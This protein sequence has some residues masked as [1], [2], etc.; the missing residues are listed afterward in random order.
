MSYLREIETINK[1]GI[2]VDF[3]FIQAINAGTTLSANASIDDTTI[4]LTSTT[5]F[6]DG[7]YV[8]IF[9]PLQNRF[10]FGEELGAV[11]GSVVTLDT[12]L[13][14]AF[15]SGDTVVPFTRDLNVNGS[16][17]SQAFAVAGGGAT[18]TLVVDICRIM[19]HMDTDSAPV[20]SDWGD[21]TNGLDNGVVLRRVD[22]MTH[23][24]FN[25]KTNAEM[26]QLCYDMDVDTAIGQGQDGISF[27]Y[28]FGGNDKHGIAI[29][30]DPGD[31]SRVN[32]SR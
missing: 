27:R 29:R 2:P 1:G 25:V 20:L 15:E 11:S 30:L 32:Y 4:T 23:N 12:P 17:T 6:E 31:F 16:T 5:G 28:S 10:Y 3:F 8:G 7:V 22:G 9:K 26:K 13:D 24:I 18:S 21:I 14:Y 19:I